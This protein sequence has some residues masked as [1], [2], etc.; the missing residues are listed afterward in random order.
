MTKISSLYAAMLTRNTKDSGTGSKIVL[1]ANIYGIDRLHYTFPPSPQKDRVQGQANLYRVAIAEAIPLD[2]QFL[3]RTYFRVAIRGTDLWRPEHVLIWGI[4]R[5][6]NPIVPMATGLDLRT[7]GVQRGN[8]VGTDKPLILSTDEAEGDVSFPLLSVSLGG[9]AVP[10]QRLL[11]LMTTADKPDAGTG[12][13]VILQIVR[14]AQL[15]VTFTLPDTPQ[16]DQRRGQANWY[17]IPVP[18]DFTK[19]S[20]ARNARITLTI[21]GTDAWLPS[22]FMVFGFDSKEGPPAYIVPLVHVDPWN[23]GWLSTDPSEGKS[24][25]ELPV[26]L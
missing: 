20:L 23:L 26:L 7:S 2:T 3:L 19:G 1:I 16:N 10:I 8:R 22:S 25:I 14:D 24:T 5:G 12:S 21:G 11:V 13:S 18:V 4:P 17:F 15:M 9:N 6:N